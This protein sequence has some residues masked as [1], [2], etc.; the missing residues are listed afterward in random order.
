MDNNRIPDVSVIVPIYNGESYIDDCMK[1]LLKQTHQNVEF[2]LV[3]D[4]SK[5]HTKEM[6]DQYAKVDDRIHVIHQQNKGLSG[7][8]NAGIAAATGKYV[9][10]FDVDDKIS[11]KLVEDNYRLAKEQDADLVMFGF[12]YFNVDENRFV[13]RPLSKDF[14]GNDQEFFEQCLVDTIDHEVFNA[15]WNKMIKRS[16]FQD[17]SLCFDSNYPIYEDI[18]F[19]S[20]LL[21]KTKK[22]V[23]N[24]QIYYDYYLKSSGSLLTRFFMNFFESVS[25]FHMNAMD[26]C[27]MYEENEKQILRF[28][29]LYS[30][31]VV[32]HLKQI[33]CQKT[34]TKEKKYEMIGKICG[35]DRFL[36]ALNHSDYA[37]NPKKRIVRRM[38][39]RKMVKSICFYYRFFS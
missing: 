37:Q 25:R 31:L 22:I 24:K 5:D 16:L 32:M 10:F 23:V 26:Y 9:Y 18:I 20:L 33:S 14:I 35:N 19:A 30:T 4:G 36:D 17:E 11:E 7:A 38:I 21:Q 1:C 27:S 2:I 6:C 3:N 28:N 8:R 12:R 34:L 39:N 29:K 13:E 15:P